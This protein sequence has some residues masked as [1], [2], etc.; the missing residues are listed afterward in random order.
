MGV[1]LIEQ[2]M[3]GPDLFMDDFYKFH[4]KEGITVGQIVSDEIKALAAPHWLSFPPSHPFIA[5]FIAIFYALLFL[6]NVSSNGFL[7]LLF[8]KESQ[9]RTPSN[10]FIFNLAVADFALMFTNGL[11]IAISPFFGNY[12][13]YGSAYCQLYGFSGA[14]TGVV[15]I[16]TMV[17]IGYDRH[18]N[19]TNAYQ[20][21]SFTFTSSLC[22][23]LLIWTYA[24]LIC[25]PPVLGVWSRMALEG[26]LITCS[27]EYCIDNVENMS[28]VLFLFFSSF[29]IPMH[30][31]IYY[32]FFIIKT[33][34]TFQKKM[35]SSSNNYRALAYTDMISTE[36]RINKMAITSV[37]IWL[38]AW[39][40]YA[41]VCLIG[42]FGPRH[43]I[44]PLVSQI[45]S[46]SAKTFPVF[47]SVVYGFSHPD[48]QKSIRK[49]F[50]KI[51]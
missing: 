37:L 31:I 50:P 39:A 30:L 9:L 45:P 17:C 20:R 18:R 26:L 51:V 42:Q 40:P 13:S 1:V 23:L 22:A 29:V 6:C 5:D 47:N 24:V 33:V 16:F 25:L 43:V 3:E 19:I 46:I 4:V 15:S 2:S 44:T 35:R 41:V 36:A 21:P 27:F 10:M 14:V 38:F 48:I 8:I 11:P 28:Y 32:Y 49:M 12:W 34:H 7:I